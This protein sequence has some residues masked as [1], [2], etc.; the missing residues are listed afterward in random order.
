[1][2]LGKFD[3][4][5]VTDFLQMI[6][7]ENEPSWL[8][9]KRLD[10]FM[11]FS[12]LKMPNSKEEEWRYTDI[13]GI[14]LDDMKLDGY[15][16]ISIT[17]GDEIVA[18]PMKE[19]LNKFSDR[20]SEH[21]F[22]LIDDND[23]FVSFVSSFWSDGTFIYVPKNVECKIPATIKLNR[24]NKP[25]YT[26]IILDEN[27]KLDIIEESYSN[28]SNPVVSTSV[29]EIIIKPNARLNYFASQILP[30]NFYDFNY[31]KASIERDGQINWFIGSFGAKLSRWK[32]ETLLRGENSRCEKYGLYIGNQ[33]QHHDIITKT[34]HLVPNTTNNILVKGVLTDQASSIYRGLIRIEKN[35]QQTMSYMGAH[36]LLLSDKSKS[37]NIPSLEI[38]ANDVK[39][40]HGSSVGQVDEEKLFYLMTRGLD[41]KSAE[42]V[43]VEGFIESVLNKFTSED[44]K[45]SFRTITS[46]RLWKNA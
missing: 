30:V 14:N 31:K 19:A 22:S 24:G 29:V 8:N 20:I 34:F 36:T 5:L 9:R 46:E 15:T 4:M 1:M 33:N 40:T 7:N 16:D 44:A 35:A 41:R 27:S 37:N 23:K 32:L 38:E 25:I 12:Q 18:L 39:A 42:N 10:M 13:S 2:R 26:L 11:K 28:A 21:I 3:F 17:A 43:I 6:K 45:E